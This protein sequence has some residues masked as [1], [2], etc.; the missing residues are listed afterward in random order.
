M[1][2]VR[3]WQLVRNITVWRVSYYSTFLWVD[4]NETSG[5]GDSF[6]SRLAEELHHQDVHTKEILRC[7]IDNAKDL[8]GCLGLRCVVDVRRAEPAAQ[9]ATS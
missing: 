9:Q 2:A 4:A 7:R 1:N 6:A 5:H 8:K 3:G